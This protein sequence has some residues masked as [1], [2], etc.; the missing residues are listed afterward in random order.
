MAAHVIR[1]P[2]TPVF[3]VAFAVCPPYELVDYEELYDLL[4]VSP[5]LHQVC[6]RGE[7]DERGGG[8]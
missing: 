3:A 4:D 5:L 8:G 2:P 7:R 6:G 1:S